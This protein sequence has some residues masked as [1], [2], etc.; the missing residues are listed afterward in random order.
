[1]CITV[2]LIQRSYILPY[3]YTTNLFTISMTLIRCNYEN[4][5]VY[6]LWPTACFCHFSNLHTAQ[7]L[8]LKH[9]QLH[10]FPGSLSRNMALCNLKLAH[11]Q[12]RTWSYTFLSSKHARSG[13]ALKLFIA[14]SSANTFCSSPFM[15]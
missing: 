11:H 15:W 13:Q 3:C 4:S 14:R 5:T 1:M 7:W 12:P 10:H 8:N 2:W 9:F 6:C